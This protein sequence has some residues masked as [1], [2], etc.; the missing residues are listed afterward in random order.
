MALD[1]LVL[2]IDETLML[3]CDTTGAPPPDVAWSKDGLTFDPSDNRVNEMGETLVITLVNEMDSGMFHCTAA[4][5]AG[6]VADSVRVTV[7]DVG[8]QNFTMTMG[9]CSVGT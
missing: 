6:T 4:S 3:E 7:V 1:D 8:A 2:P 9:R 5:T